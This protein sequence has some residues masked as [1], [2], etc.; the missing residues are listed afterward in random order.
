MPLPAALLS[1]LALAP[2][3]AAAPPAERPA[4]EPIPVLI[5]S[6]ANNHWWEWTT[7][8]LQRILEES[9]KF[10]V[11]VTTEPA[12]ALADR[13][14]LAG[15]RAVVLD[16][17]GPRWGDAAEQ[18]FLD[19]V[20]GGLG[21]VVIHAANNAFPG[22]EEYEELVALCWR[23]GTGH[24]R[25]HAFDVD[26]VDRD[27]PITRDLPDLVGHPDELYHELVHMHDADFRVLATARSTR[28]S[29]GTG[30]DEP[31]VIVKTY[32]EGRVFHTPLGH[33]WEGAEHQKA[34]H[35]DPAFRDLVVRGT[36]WAATGD[37]TDRAPNR[38]TDAERAAGWR[39]LFD[40]D[41]T[42]GWVAFR[43]DAFP[44]QGWEVADG[45]LHHLP[46]G[47][48]GDLVTERAFRD[49][50]LRFDWKVAPGANS[51]VI[52]RVGD[53]HDAT[54][55]TGPEFQVLDDA[56]HADLDPRHSAGALYALHAPEGKRLNPAGQWNR[57]RILVLGN[58]IEHQVNG[59]TVVTADMG[60]GDWRARVEESKFGA[61]PDF[62]SLP[63]GRIALQDHG[64]EVWY[65]NLFVRDLAPD[66]ARERDLLGG[67][68][69]GWEAHLPDGGSS[70]DGARLE[71]VWTLRE[72]GV[73]VCAGQPI[74]YLQTRDSFDNYTLRLRWRFDP[75]KGAGNSG[76][77]LRKIGPDQVWPRSIEGQLQSGQAG[78]FWNIGDFPMQPD[79]DRTNGRNTRRLTTAE[80]ELG[81]W[82]DYDI[83]VWKGHVVLRVNGQVLNQAHDCMEVPG[84]IALQSEGAEIH[85]RDVRLMPLP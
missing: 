24:G 8:S 34:S 62:A 29:G 56:A 30:E 13:E 80:R 18:A 40:G 69:S 21:V 43:G 71:D 12:E 59:V 15:Y 79:P 46:G 60:S 32:G 11:E 26:V 51:G 16:Y 22:W 36:E 75:E 5:V 35:T 49:F 74:G 72:D 44:A 82:N 64:N 57:G 77:L 6:G 38:L 45:T 78:D 19:A 54:W 70:P 55:Q 25:F 9:G 39:P 65:R 1:L 52:Y 67:D 41:S 66:P 2:L 50:E 37:V 81:E 47:G 68:L 31:M 3:L 10:A 20:R 14:R 85:F 7:P 33:V 28:E 23:E 73:L 4:D 83:T 48:G 27:H 53:Q 61:M 84:R 17:N 42:D 76:V 58:R 63:A